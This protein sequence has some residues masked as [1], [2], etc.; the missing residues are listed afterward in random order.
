MTVLHFHRFV[1]R[2]DDHEVLAV[3][4][5]FAA[6]SVLVLTGE[7]GAEVSAALAAVLD[8]VT[9]AAGQDR[10]LDV[11]AH[12][13]VDGTVRVTDASDPLAAAMTRDHGLLGAL[14]ATENVALGVL[15]HAR[16][17]S[18]PAPVDAVAAALD[19]V[20]VPDAVRHNLAEQ[21]SGGQ[22]QRVALARALV[23]DAAVTALDDP[24]SELDPAS[25]VV[26]DR[27]I[28]DA[29]A[30]GGVVLVGRSDDQ[31]MPPTA[32]RIQVGEPRRG[33]QHG[34]HR[35]GYL[36]DPGD[37]SGTRVPSHR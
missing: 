29:A 24:A 6:G 17:R 30:R 36:E 13:A 27:A 8:A 21:L 20:G 31:P 28:A 14:T 4:G 33:R 34:R 9:S 3:D 19:A 26:V 23:A 12:V 35:S 2:L 10:L 7:D 25:V 32:V 16:E 37:T 18:R 5:E 11:P 22:Q 1:V 15:A